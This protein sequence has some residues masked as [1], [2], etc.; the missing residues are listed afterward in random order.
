MK[1]FVSKVILGRDNVSG[2]LAL[3]LVALIALGCTCGKNLDLANLGKI[4]NSTSTPA[5]TNADD[6]VPSKEYLDAIIAETTADFNYAITVNDFSSMYEKASSDF[7]STYTE[8][9]FKNYFQD[10]VKKKKVI[11]PI[12][13]KAVS[14]DPQL[15][16]EPS[17]R[18]EQGLD[19]LVVKGKYPTKPVPVTF[20]YEYVK[21]DD[22]WK[23]LK[24]VVKLI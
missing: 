22:E 5:A 11:A 4:A 13:S 23:L 15:S 6:G 9:E 2:F 21:R 20:E 3:C 8:A 12:L 19:I 18:T 17:I 10:F 16:P 7:K 1:N 14:M 24:L